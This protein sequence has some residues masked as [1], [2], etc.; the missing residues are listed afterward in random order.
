M[1]LVEEKSLMVRL[2]SA[3]KLRD[4]VLDESGI[5]AILHKVGMLQKALQESDIRRDALDSEFAERSIRLG[6]CVS[7]IGRTGM[8]NDFREQRVEVRTRG[9]T[10]VGERIDPHARSRWRVE[11]GQRSARGLRTSVGSHRLHVDAHLNSES[12]RLRNVS[13]AHPKFRERAAR[14]EL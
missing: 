6:N 4:I 12:A 13:L 7:E 11:R 5:D 2:R 3:D 10:G 8:R 14:R 9:I 1:R